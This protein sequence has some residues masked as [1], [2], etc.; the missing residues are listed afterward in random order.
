MNYYAQVYAQVIEILTQDNNLKCID[1]VAEIAKYYPKVVCDAVRR[2]K[3][4]GL[5]EQAKQML[6][7]GTKIEAIKMV[8]NVS[9][10]SLKEAKELVDSWEREDQNLES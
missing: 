6:R 8:R 1:I 9:D 2:L 3:T 10:L 5:Y 4:R 7:V